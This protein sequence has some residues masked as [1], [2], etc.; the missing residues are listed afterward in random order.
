[1]VSVQLLNTKLFIFHNYFK[2]TGLT[3]ASWIKRNRS[4]VFEINHEQ[5]L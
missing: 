1:M 2:N 4:V 5:I 3:A